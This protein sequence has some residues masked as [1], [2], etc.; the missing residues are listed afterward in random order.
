[1]FGGWVVF[2]PQGGGKALRVPYAGFKGDYQSI[3]YL[4]PTPSNY[5]RL[6]KV[7]ANGTYVAQPEGVPFTLQGD[8]IPFIQVHLDHQAREARMEVFDAVTGKAWHLARRQHYLSRNTQA[9]SFFAWGWDGVTVAGN[10]TYEVPNGQY[11]IKLTVTKALGD[12]A[13]PAH[14]ETWTSPVITIARP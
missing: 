8:D 12:P 10:K 5:P 1:L 9:T 4:V 11:V 3:Q 2:T 6:A 13:N 7:Q 14:V